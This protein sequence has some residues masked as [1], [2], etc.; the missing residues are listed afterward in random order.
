MNSGYDGS[1]P[2]ALGG[3][4][5][6]IWWYFHFYFHLVVFS[7]LLSFGGIFTFFTAINVFQPQ[8]RRRLV[9]LDEVLAWWMQL[10]GGGIWLLHSLEIT[11]RFFV[12]I[13][14]F[15]KYLKGSENQC[16]P[17]GG[18]HL[19]CILLHLPWKVNFFHHSVP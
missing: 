18:W 17:F 13:S 3:I 6:F 4:F 5:T 15:G 12:S 9:E 14:F 10:L 7:L 19:P 16:W 8:G 1:L 2:E 11:Q